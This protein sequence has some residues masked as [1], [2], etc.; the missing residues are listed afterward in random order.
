[1]NQVSVNTPLDAVLKLFVKDKKAFN[2]VEEIRE[3]IS[4]TIKDKK[5]K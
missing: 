1:M 5:K 4:K 2:L 3:F